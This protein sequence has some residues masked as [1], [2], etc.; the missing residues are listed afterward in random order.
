MRNASNNAMKPVRVFKNE[1]LE[2]VKKNRDKHVAEYDEAIEG[3]KT[4]VARI[5]KSNNKL[6]KSRD[7]KKIEMIKPYPAR[8]VSY[9]DCYDR[10]IAMLTMSV[11]E[12]VELTEDVF[13]QLVL[14]NWDW[15]RTFDST[16]AIYK[17]AR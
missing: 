10:A 6:A 9:Q 15:K 12:H 8:P 3:Y 5:A 7:L 11:D 4:S 13:N 14:D 1:L 17:S 2:T 16:N